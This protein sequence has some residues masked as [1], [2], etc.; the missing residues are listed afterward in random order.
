MKKIKVKKN[1]DGSY[2][3]ELPAPRMGFDILKRGAFFD[4]RPKRERT[5]EGQN[6]QWKKD[7]E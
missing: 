5:R 4:S 7:N 3:L 1:E 2:T 6:K